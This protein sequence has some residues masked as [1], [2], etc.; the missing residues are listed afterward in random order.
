[1]R[2]TQDAARPAADDPVSGR[3]RPGGGILGIGLLA[4]GTL[5]LVAAGGLLWWRR[6]AAVFE[7]VASAAIAWCF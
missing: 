6:G 5:C 3:A 1:M 2:A 7:D 4:A